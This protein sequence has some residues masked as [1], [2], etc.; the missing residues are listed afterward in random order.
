M[1]NDPTPSSSLRRWLVRWMYLVAIGHL[2][3]GMVL[4]VLPYLSLTDNYHLQVEQ[5]FWGGPA[6][7]P[8]RAQQQ[9]WI[10]LFGATIQSMSVWM[11]LL[12][13][14]GDTLQRPIIWRGLLLG[15]LLWAPQ[16]LWLSWQAG[17]TYHIVADIAALLALLPPLWMLNRIDRNSSVSKNASNE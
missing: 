4:I 11:I 1:P 17:V 15:V 7:A 6:P 5:F 2:L 12:V 16:D 3:V 9:W 13:Y 8:A 10:S 14:L